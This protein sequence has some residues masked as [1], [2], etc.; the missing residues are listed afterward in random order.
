MLFF[1]LCKKHTDRRNWS[2]GTISY[3]SNFQKIFLNVIFRYVSYNWIVGRKNI[4]FQEAFLFYRR[5]SEFT[6]ISVPRCTVPGFRRGRGWWC[7]WRSGLR[8]R[9]SGRRAKSSSR[10]WRQNGTWRASC[11]HLKH[12]QIKFCPNSVIYLNSET[13]SANKIL[14][15]NAVT[16]IET[17]LII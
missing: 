15:Q 5:S 4:I 6:A 7:S 8:L 1:I 2:L 10:S 13:V 11:G 12:K 3:L 16:P 14:I 17:M 9:P